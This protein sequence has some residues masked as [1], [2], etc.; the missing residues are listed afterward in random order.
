MSASSQLLVKHNLEANDVGCL[1]ELL[2]RGE[3]GA[4]E[5]LG[6][7]NCIDEGNS[8]GD[9]LRL[10]LRAR[11]RRDLL[12]LFLGEALG[13]ALSD[14]EVGGGG[15]IG[16]KRLGT[17]IGCLLGISLGE[18]DGVPKGRLLGL[19]EGTLNGRLLGSAKGKLAGG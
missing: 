14:P 16:N 5:L 9:S 8:L 6:I 11:C 10:R 13:A 17:G 18:D 1:L 3:E 7:H 12:G 2:L 15:I 19:E 4:F